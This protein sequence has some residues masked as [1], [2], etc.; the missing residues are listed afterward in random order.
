MLRATFLQASFRSVRGCSSTVRRPA[1][2]PNGSRAACVRLG[3]ATSG[4]V[5]KRSTTRV[6]R[7][8]NKSLFQELLTAKWIADRR[9]LIITGPCGV[10]KTWL[11]CALAQ[12]ACR[13]GTTVLYRRLPRLFDEL[14]LAHGDGRF[15]RLLR[16]LTKTQLLILDE[17]PSSPESAAH[18]AVVRSSC[19]FAFAANGGNDGPH[20]SNRDLRWRSALGRNHL[21][22]TKWNIL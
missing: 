19:F 3:C 5:R 18:T 9:N 21:K 1:A 4:P 17:R 6:R 11:A 20:R 15:P 22:P 7:G 8:L 10:G 14:E 13:Y 2:R 16:S 12:A